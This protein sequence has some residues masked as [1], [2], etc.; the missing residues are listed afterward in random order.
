MLCRNFF[1]ANTV[2]RTFA[3]GSFA[4]TSSQW[5]SRS[6][7]HALSIAICVRTLQL[8]PDSPTHFPYRSPLLSIHQ[9]LLPY[10]PSSA[11]YCQSNYCTTDTRASTLLFFSCSSKSLTKPL[12]SRSLHSTSLHNAFVLVLVS[13]CYSCRSTP[14]CAP[15]S[16]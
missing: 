8:L 16:D 14:I 9:S 3:S 12:I 15:H 1:A 11:R 13:L 5:S 6:R 10:T 2:R 7:Y 4:S